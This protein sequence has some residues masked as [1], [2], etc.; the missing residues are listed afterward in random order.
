MENILKEFAVLNSIPRPSRH[1]EAVAKYLEKRGVDLGFPTVR[2][3]F[4][5][6]IMEIPATKGYEN[7]PLTI[8]QGHMDMVC[9]GGADY[10]PLTD[11]IITVND[12][13]TLKA[14][15]TS[16]GADDGMGVAMILALITGEYE[17]G[18]LRGIFTADEESGMSG[19]Q[20]LDKKYLEA[21][22]LIN[23][24][25][26]DDDSICIG[27][28]GCLTVEYKKFAVKE[29]MEGQGF[30]LSLSGLR[31]GH[32]GCEIHENR[33]NAIKVMG[34]FLTYLVKNNILFSIGDI[35]GGKA[36]NVIAP[37]IKTSIIVAKEDVPKFE[38]LYL[39]FA[40]KIENQFPL[41][42]NMIFGCVKADI[43]QGYLPGDTRDIALFLG[44]CPQGVKTMSQSVPGFVS[45]S[46]NLGV[47][48]G[49][50]GIN[51]LISYRSD[52]N[53]VMEDFA[54]E[55]GDMGKTYGFVG[56]VQSESPAWTPKSDSYMEKLA[57]EL[58][59][60][61]MGKSPHVVSVHA[62]LECCYFAVQN[63]S[64][65]MIS[66]GPLIKECH[67]VKETLY[68]E[69]LSLVMGWFGEILKNLK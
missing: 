37:E 49:E 35:V 41:E 31:G 61:K 15:G 52:K 17:H 23:L 7:L 58:Y 29:P 36:L 53:E 5:N 43:N 40:K 2:D 59:V 56:E 32:S 57:Y 11:A 47:I 10:N 19:V 55:V 3:E 27:C 12:G 63:P 4:N 13:K 16:L 69:T 18:P 38:T 9:V 1:E 33:A 66:I 39:D 44:Q 48:N 20:N 34:D 26:E 46:N 60:K 68:L 6:V 65:E 30:S 8:V 51:L 50:N 14:K 24:D 45:T 22:Y 25:W 67:S 54:K 62:G 21:K 64:L 28:A 42:K